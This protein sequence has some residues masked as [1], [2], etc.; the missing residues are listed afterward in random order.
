M[1]LLIALMGCKKPQTPEVAPPPVEAEEKAPTGE[2]GSANPELPPVKADLK[3]HMAVHLSVATSARDA[4]VRGDLEAAKEFMGWLAR[5]EGPE[6]LPEDWQSY[7]PYVLAMS[8][9]AKAGSEAPTLEV[10]AT[11]IAQVAAACG[12][13]HEESNGGLEFPQT[14]PPA[15][16]EGVTPHMARHKWAS[17]QLW[18]GMLGPSE[19]HWNLGA[20]AMVEDPMETEEMHHGTNMSPEEQEFDAWLHTLGDFGGHIEDKSRRAE[21]YGAMLGTCSGCHSTM[22]LGPG[23]TTPDW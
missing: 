10:A 21:L 20:A 12:S 7:Q 23:A 11:A 13:C 17:E 2:S 16:K 6:D 3:A 15:D 1:L 22:G 5:H 8:Q 19:L 4:V 18:L 9:S 14:E